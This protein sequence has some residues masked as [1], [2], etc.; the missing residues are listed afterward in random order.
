MLCLVIYLEEHYEKRRRKR[1]FV[2]DYSKWRLDRTFKSVGTCV[3]TLTLV[4]ARIQRILLEG[5]RLRVLEVKRDAKPA[6]AQILP[7]FVLT[8]SKYYIPWPQLGKLDVP[9][10]F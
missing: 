4:A 9:V 8:S 6:K 3:I 7:N 10:V 1:R 5:R 2:G